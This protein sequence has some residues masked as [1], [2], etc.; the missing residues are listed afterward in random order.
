MTL[1]FDH[2]MQSVPAEFV[3]Y[4]IGLFLCAFGGVFPRTIVAVEAWRLGGGME[5]IRCLQTLIK[6]VE[7]YQKASR[8]DDAIDDDHDGIPD[9]EEISLSERIMRKGR[10]AVKVS[11][12]EE[13]NKAL[14]RFYTGWVGI[15]ASMSS[16]YA[17][18]AALGASLGE[19]AVRVFMRCTLSK[20]QSLIPGEFV[21]WAPKVLQWLCKCIGIIAAWRMKQVLSAFHSA[22]RGGKLVGETL[23]RAGHQRGF[24]AGNPEDTYIDEM[25]GFSLAAVGFSW[26][27]SR[28]FHVF[29][30][31][32]G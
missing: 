20:M 9:V 23:V 6:Q 10:L 4:I 29:H 31:Y 12:P 17:R 8:A 1:K 14:S 19:S 13:I 28:G 11:E 30:N 15:V 26:Q 16:P 5:A 24:I 18:T 3:K 22:V 32:F 2:L 7:K 25:V 27:L 21:K